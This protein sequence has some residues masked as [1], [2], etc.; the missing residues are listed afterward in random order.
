[1]PHDRRSI[2]L[3]LSPKELELCEKINALCE[4]YVVTLSGGPLG[5]DML[6]GMNDARQALERFW[7]DEIRYGGS[8]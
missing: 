6:S 1:L 2:R 3:R 5:S 7:S 8:R 4:T